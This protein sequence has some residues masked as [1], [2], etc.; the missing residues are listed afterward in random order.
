MPLTVAE[1]M[2]ARSFYPRMIEILQL[3]GSSSLMGLPAETDFDS[4]IR[5]DLDHYLATDTSSALP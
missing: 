1:N 2:Y 5:P 4:E 3:L